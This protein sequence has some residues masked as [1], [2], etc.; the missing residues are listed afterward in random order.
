[1]KLAGTGHRPDKLG[2][3]DVPAAHG[4]VNDSGLAVLEQLEPSEVM[5]GMACGWDRRAL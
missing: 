4:R 3:W 2:G 5:S 1:M